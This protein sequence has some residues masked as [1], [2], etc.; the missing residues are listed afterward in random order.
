MVKELEV[1]FSASEEDKDKFTGG[2]RL[3]R[4]VL[5]GLIYS[6]FLDYFAEP[7]EERGIFCRTVGDSKASPLRIY[8]T[9]L[10]FWHF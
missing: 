10:L 2:A 1:Q 8:T 6:Q 4:P 9:G 7:F 3:I 5:R